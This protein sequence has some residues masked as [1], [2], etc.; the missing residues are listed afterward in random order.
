MAWLNTT[1]TMSVV[2]PICSLMAALTLSNFQKPSDN[3]SF[4]C[5]H[6]T[7]LCCN[8]SSICGANSYRRSSCLASIGI[9]TSNSALT[10]KVNSAN[11]ATTP[12]VRD[13]PSFSRRSTTGSNR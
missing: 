10:I 1:P 6:G 2:W 13:R 8:Q 5:T 9:S 7:A 11:T 3:P 12:Q 4:D